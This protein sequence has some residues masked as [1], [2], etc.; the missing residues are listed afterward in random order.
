MIAFHRKG[1]DRRHNRGGAMKRSS[2]LKI[3][4]G[5]VGSVVVVSVALH[6]TLLGNASVVDLSSRSSGLPGE[7]PGGAGT[8]ARAAAAAPIDAADAAAAKDAAGIA[9]A[10]PWCSGCNRDPPA[11]LTVAASK[12][13]VQSSSLHDRLLRANP[14]APEEAAAAAA[15]AEA[16]PA[17]A[18]AVVLAHQH[19][20][21]QLPPSTTTPVDHL[22]E[23]SA[24]AAS[25]DAAAAA[26]ASVDAEPSSSA[27]DAAADAAAAAAMP[28]HRLPPVFESD[29]IDHHDHAAISGVERRRSSSSSRSRVRRR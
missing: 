20:H 4:A 12:G 25:S 16:A 24:G 10:E 19:V 17:P 18:P 27:A 9:A 26:V 21:Q 23:A 29:H 28:I 13:L 8:Q 15:A 7:V 11:A 3:L 14:K 2:L 5:V 22:Q 6:S 1:N